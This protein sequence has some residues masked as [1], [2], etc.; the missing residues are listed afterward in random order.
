MRIFITMLGYNR[1][2]TVRDAMIN[3]E[4]FTTDAEHRRLVKTV[5]LCQYPLPSVEENRAK[6]IKAA[7]EFGWWYAEIPNQGVMANHNTALHDYCHI[8][9]GD[10]YVTFD[11]DVRFR[12]V[13]WISAMIE[14]LNSDPTAMFCSSALDFHH[15]DWMYQHPYN[16]KVTTLPSGLNIARYNCLI[17]WASGMWR[18]EFLKTRPRD[19]AQMGKYY[20]WS[21]H[22]DYD[23]L[24][25]HRKTWLSVADYVDYHLGA[26]DALYTDWKQES[27][28]GKT[29]LSFNEWLEKRK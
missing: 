6:I 21:E 15:H 13:G 28:G 10:F 9:D 24:L 27:A 3:L 14:A 19:F 16:R 8:D 5:F 18:G 4:E 7:R 25:F 17:S 29:D 2:E 23:R 1:A 12:K 26:P 11:P 22:A 20:G